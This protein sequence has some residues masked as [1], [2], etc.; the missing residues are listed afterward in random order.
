M[1]YLRIIVWASYRSLKVSVGAMM[2]YFSEGQQTSV[3]WTGLRA[4]LPS[5]TKLLQVMARSDRCVHCI[6]GTHESQDCFYVPLEDSLSQKHLRL[7]T[8]WGPSAS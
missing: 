1:N 4:T 5:L 8:N 2:W 6:S 7:V 3:H